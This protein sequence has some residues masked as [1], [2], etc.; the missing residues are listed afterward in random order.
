MNKIAKGLLPL[1]I[2]ISSVKPDPKN[3][4]KHNDRNLETIKNSIEVYGQRKPIICN[5]KTKLIEAGNGL[6][7]AAKELK[8]TEIA[9]IF[10]DNDDQLARAYSLIDNQSA[11]LSDWDLPALKDTLEQLDTGAFDMAKTGFT[12]DEIEELMTQ[13]YS[14]ANIDDLLNEVDYDISSAH[15]E[16]QADDKKPNVM[17]DTGYRSH[18]TNTDLKDFAT[19]EDVVKGMVAE[20]MQLNQQERKSKKAPQYTLTFE[21]SLE[22]LRNNPQQPTL[23]DMGE[24]AR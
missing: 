4:R 7:M 15:I 1:A 11:L 18:F 9:A 14:P 12:T 20:I 2:K 19:M 3:V 13:Y 17:T 8:W 21:P 6:W 22:Y 10:V 23:F 16:F 5:S 24:L